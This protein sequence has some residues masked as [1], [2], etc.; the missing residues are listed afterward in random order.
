[1]TNE[2]ISAGIEEA[3]RG[4]ISHDANEI[5]LALPSHNVSPEYKRAISEALRGIC[6]ESVRRAIVATSSEAEG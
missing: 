2:R 6:S 1:M 5:L 3:R 4:I